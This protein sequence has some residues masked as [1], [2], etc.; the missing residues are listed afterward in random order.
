M[1]PWEASIPDCE[2]L[3]RLVFEEGLTNNQIAAQ[4]GIA[5]P[6]LR[7]HLKKCGIVRPSRS[8]LPRLDHKGDGAVP[9]DLDSSQGHHMDPTVRLLRARNALAHGRE[10]PT[11]QVGRLRVMEK[12][13]QE[14]RL[15]VSYN[16]DLGFHFVRRNDNIDDPDSI[17]RRPETTDD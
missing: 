7:Y 11:D 6:T 3:K 2:T 5:E 13:L 1:K 16:R 12:T 14:E 4:I 17:V 8:K 9:W 15:V 10:V